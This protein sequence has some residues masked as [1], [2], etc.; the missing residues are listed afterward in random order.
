MERDLSLIREL[1]LRIKK[2]PD[3]G[4]GLDLNNEGYSKTTVIYNLGLAINVGLVDGTVGWLQGGSDRYIAT[5]MSLTWEGH[6]FLDSVRQEDVWKKTQE[7]A[8]NA[9][10]KIAHISLDLVKEVAI[11]VIK[12]QLGLQS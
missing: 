6:D 1:L 4:K 12:S 3:R 2:M 10:H 5:V 9:G 8:E 7:R 11:S